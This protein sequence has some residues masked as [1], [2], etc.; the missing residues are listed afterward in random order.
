MTSFVC[1]DWLCPVVTACS[2]LVL[3]AASAPGGEPAG[4]AVQTVTPQASDEPLVNP[5]RGWVAY[6]RAD[7]FEEIDANALAL[8]S[9]GYARFQWADLNP[10]EGKY[11]WEPIESFLTGWAKMGK[12][13]A[14]GVMAASSHSRKPFVTP[15]WVF[16][17]GAEYKETSVEGT[18]HGRPGTKV[19]PDFDHPVYL[20]KLEAFL[21]AFAARYDGDP[22]IEFI[23]IRSYGNWGEAHMAHLGGYPPISEEAFK[24][25]VQIHL[26]AFK[27]T[28]LILPLN[29][30]NR[31][32]AGLARWAVENGIGVRR[33][34]VIGNSDGSETAI[35]LGRQPAVFEYY[36]SY[37]FLK[38]SGFWDGSS[39]RSGYGYPLPGCVERG[40]PTYMQF[41]WWGSS[42]VRT[43][44]E[45]ERE[46]IEKLSNRM[47]YHFVLTEATLPVHIVPG[48]A[49]TLKLEVANQGVAPI[50]IP[51][52][53]FVGLFDG[54]G[55]FVARAEL[56]GV[57]TAKWQP[58]RTTAQDG[59]FTFEKLKPGGYTLAL[60]LFT[61]PDSKTPAIALGIRGRRAD[62][63]HPLAQVRVG[64]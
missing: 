60:G 36:G 43:W 6:G 34:G 56:R 58:G 11:D 40:R 53:P 57:N 52:R 31:H 61:N 62:R 51:A 15:K 22:R 30:G 29:D 27:K 17:A 55:E 2:V 50:Y 8:A 12:T 10:D 25:H 13:G 44:L 19:V 64:D 49:A 20:A 16:D 3:L 38:K 21:K 63:W 24:E 7:G 45:N 46:L 32:Y 1:F 54:D 39:S 9:V 37:E 59:T 35:A 14:L 26:R 41:G 5:G 23:D 47:G 48:K 28:Q 33:D 42:G 4:D 18:A